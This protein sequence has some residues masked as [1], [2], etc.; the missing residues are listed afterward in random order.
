MTRSMEQVETLVV[1]GGQA[2]LAMS[3]ELT[4]HGVEHVVLERGHI[5]Q[6]W[7]DRWE[8]FCLVTPNWSVQLPDGV[9]DGDD[10]DGFMP[11]DEIVA[12]LE[13]YASRSRVPV[14]EG[15]AVR[16]LDT[17]PAGGFVARTSAGELQARR[18]VLATGAY[19]RPHR[20]VGSET[21]PRDLAQIDLHEYQHPAALPPGRVLIVG[22]GQSGCQLAEELH[23]AGR[24]VVLACGKAPWAPRR[25]GDH[26][27]VWWLLESGFLDGP[28]K[29]LPSSNARLGANIL[30]TGHGKP[31]D[32]HLRTLR[33]LGVT[34][35]GHFL[36]A[37]GDHA[38]FARDLTETVAWG[39]AR[40]G[41]LMQLF[42]K[43]A[44]ELGMPQPVA[45]DPEPFDDRAP[46]V[47]SL[48]GF[49]AFIF[50]GGFRPDYRS[51]LP[52]PAAFDDLGF[53]IQTD[54]ASTVVDGLYFVGVPFLR[55]RKSPLLLGVGE[56]AS[57]VGRTIAG[58]ATLA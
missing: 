52:W 31:H 26:D 13:R 56:D 46:E 15:V 24:E 22:S 50:A 30:A 40:H 34:L 38:R 44:A 19:Q 32:L 5:G 42:G 35:V 27:A 28:V 57:I 16:S 11:R 3:H 58:G 10:P 4:R 14:R 45:S 54:G 53:P 51:W 2:G 43:T 20:P 12:F 41:E 21:L 17:A 48:A 37:D 18:V 6:S 7:R 49:G 25:I 47:V 29:S 8:S 55:T 33:A 36:G 23:E 39:D 1:G 9:Y